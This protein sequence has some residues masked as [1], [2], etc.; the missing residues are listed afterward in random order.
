MN[1]INTAFLQKLAL[2]FPTTIHPQAEIV[3]ERSMNWLAEHKL[4][5]NE[6]NLDQL[7]RAKPVFLIARLHPKVSV[8]MLELLAD[9]YLWLYALDDEYCDDEAWYRHPGNQT[10]SLISLVQVL[11]TPQAAI[12]DENRFVPALRELVQRIGECASPTQMA[13]WIAGVQEYFLG[14]LWE[15]TLRAQG[16]VPD[17]DEYVSMRRI[18]GAIPVCQ[19][20]MD[21]TAHYEI[22]AAEWNQP[23][24]RTLSNIAA[25]VSSW[26]NDILSYAKE[27]LI[28][29]GTSLN[30]VSTLARLHNCSAQEAA[31][32]A[33]EIRNEQVTKFQQLATRLALNSSAEVRQYLSDLEYWMRGYL[34]WMLTS[35]RYSLAQGEVVEKSFAKFSVA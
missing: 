33:V 16:A 11:E 9:W 27:Q 1:W 5:L 14:L 32:I 35:S 21:L 31:K 13:R 3:S 20:L 7:A 25:D 8:D 10:K 6:Q 22:P 24:L 28:G 4:Y 17:F 19:T 2:P 15:A 18:S 34:E 26:D 30:L 29:G 23:D 12:T